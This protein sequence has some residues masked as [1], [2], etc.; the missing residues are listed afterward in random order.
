MSPGTEAPG[1]KRSLVFIFAFLACPFA[2]RAVDLDLKLE[3]GAAA[4]LSRPQSQRFQLGGAASIKG[5]VGF[6]GGV[7]NLTAGLTYLGL[8]AQS[9]FASTSTGTAW[10]PSAGLRIQLPRES[11]ASRLRRPHES[12]SFFGAKPWIDGDLMY[13]RTGGL[14]RPGFATAVGLSFPIGAARSYWLG[15]FV[16]YMQIFQ[17]GRPGFDTRDAN[18]LIVGLS[19][20]TG[21]RFNSS[22]AEP[23]AAVQ[24]AEK[25]AAVEVVQAAPAAAA[26]REDR[27]GDGVFDDADACPDVAGP[28]S[29]G[30]CPVYEK[31]VVKP[32]KLELKEK[33][34]FARN[35]GV[36]APASYPALDD[37][38]KALQDNKSFRVAIEGH[39]SSE[40]GE[41]HN[42]LLSD[43]RA[44]AVVDYIA[45]H[46]VARD[47]L[48]SRGFSSSRPI[49]SNGTESGRVANRRVEFVVSL[50]I[51]KEGGV[52]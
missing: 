28:G 18:I 31:V 20:E 41:D 11:D 45:T 19:L 16:R 52:R 29:N 6:E 39:A 25:P 23:V 17:G 21:T 2:A 30:G 44:G 48:L 24:P 14:N 37:V 5:L 1:L 10:A 35:Q 22:P 7:V 12:E 32:D 13:V 3:P 38:A 51:L 43:Q 9:G 15:P 47:R 33:I 46:G 4:S 42:Q 36:I 34:Q 40:G 49:E 27:D 8:P 26:A 50:I